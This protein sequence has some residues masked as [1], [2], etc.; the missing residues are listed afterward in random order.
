M[1]RR[2]LVIVAA[3][4]LAAACEKKPAT[5]PLL[6]ELVAKPAAVDISKLSAPALFEHVPSDTPYMIA[7][8][9][10]IP[11]E[12][13]AK[14]KRAM[15]PAFGSVFAQLRAAADDGSVDRLLL[16]IE[17]ELEG[18]WNAKGLESLGFNASPRFAFY[19]LGVMPIVFRIEVRDDKVVRATVERIAQRAQ[20]PLPPVQTQD[21]RS[22][23]RV[24]SGSGD[25]VAIISLADNQLVLAAGR[26]ADVDRDIALIIGSVK[27]PSNMAGGKALAEIMVKH[28]FGPHMIGFLDTRK[29]MTQAMA[30]AKHPVTPAC[31]TEVERLGARVPR[32]VMGYSLLT[33]SVSSG[34]AV[35]E[36][37]PDL[38][39]QLEGMR[40]EVPGLSEAVAGKPMFAFGVGIQLDGARLLAL[41]AM[42]A[43]RRLGETCDLGKLVEGTADASDT[44]ARPLPAFLASATGMVMA[45]HE[46]T[47]GTSSPI[48]EKVEGYAA[49][50]STDAKALF[51]QIQTLQP[52]LGKLGIQPDGRFHPV[53]GLPIPFPVHAGVGDRSI[54]V[55]VGARGKTLG[56]AVIGARATG[57]APFL[58]MS[59]DYGQF[60]ELQSRMSQLAGGTDPLQQVQQNLNDGLA[61][62]F[63]RAAVTV[64]AQRHGLA[65][66][67]TIE[68]K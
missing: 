61:K 8:F 24:Q 19:G 58:S 9:E 67:G 29:T 37:A 33:T 43:L 42:T 38:V 21:S 55:S 14:L 11:L 22:F 23:W 16:A 66:W 5:A 44:L 62:L 1:D 13:Y 65:F 15:G 32:A 41:D 2:H 7:A 57:K 64:D 68:M 59:Y 46:I 35:L 50:T 31:T 51:G 39:T 4:S 34:G 25:M 17:Q 63:G 27:P 52:Q 30:Y 40:T 28:G 10:A 26:A 6:P 3:L 18:K 54:V 45:L 36:L 49:I 47:F 48:P 12:Y 56:E 53:A 20:L 60:F